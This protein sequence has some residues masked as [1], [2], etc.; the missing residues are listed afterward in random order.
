MSGKK[1]HGDKIIGNPHHIRLRYDRS[2]RIW[3][4]SVE[5]SLGSMLDLEGEYGMKTG[6]ALDAGNRESGMRNA[7][8]LSE[9]LKIPVVMKKTGK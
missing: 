7:I 3:W 9:K 5:D 4:S 8:Q 2:I 6:F 1:Y